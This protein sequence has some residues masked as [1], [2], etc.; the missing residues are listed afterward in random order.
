MG[1]HLIFHFDAEQDHDNY[2]KWNASLIY[3][4]FSILFSYVTHY[5]NESIMNRVYCSEYNYDNDGILMIVMIMTMIITLINMIK[6]F[7][8]MLRVVMLTI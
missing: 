8:I 5:Y 1:D 7:V 6:M 4:M 3:S 2:K